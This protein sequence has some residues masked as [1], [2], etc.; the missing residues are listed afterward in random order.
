MNSVGREACLVVLLASCLHMSKSPDPEIC[1][2]T[3]YTDVRIV[4]MIADFTCYTCDR[5]G[6]PD[7]L[8]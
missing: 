2:G 8:H 6:L 5:Q 7:I 1:T 3:R 4:L